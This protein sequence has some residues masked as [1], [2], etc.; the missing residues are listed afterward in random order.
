MLGAGGASGDVNEAGLG[1]GLGR[2]GIRGRAG[3]KGRVRR[4]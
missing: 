3:I 2:A 1:A 4:G